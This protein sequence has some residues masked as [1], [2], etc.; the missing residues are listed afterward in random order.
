L[1]IHH[2][3]KVNYLTGMRI[4]SIGG[5]NCKWFWKSR[6]GGEGGLAAFVAIFA[7]SKPAPLFL[8]NKGWTIIELPRSLK[9]VKQDRRMEADDG[10]NKCVPII[11]KAALER[12]NE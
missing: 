12:Q 5:A 8:Q 4:L 10:Q 6:Q 11:C 1:K 7:K 9:F 3:R 2:V